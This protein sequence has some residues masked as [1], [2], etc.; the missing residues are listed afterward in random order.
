METKLAHITTQY[1]RF[2][3]NQV[4]TEGHLN[5][6][7]DYFDD[8]I[9]LSRIC[10]DGVGIVCGFNLTCNANNTLEISQGSAVTTDGDLFQMYQVDTDGNKSLATDA[11]VYTHFKAYVQ[12]P[13]K[14]LYSPY[15]FQGENQIPLFEL[16]T[17]GSDT[18]AK[19]IA[20]MLAQAGFA[21]KDGVALLYLENY[22]KEK[23]LCVSLSCDNQG[24]EIVG[25]YKV[26]VT[27]IAGA[28][29]IKSN[30]PTLTATNFEA[31]CYALPDVWHNRAIMLKEDFNSY[32][33]LKNK[34][35]QE[36][37][38]NDVINR[39]KS[40]YG[41]LLNTMGMSQL[42]TI[43][44]LKMDELFSY[45]ADNVPPDF[46]YRYDLLKDIIDSYSEIKTLLAVAEA[47]SCCANLDAF[48]KHIMLG[49]LTKSG[50]CYAYRHGFYKAPT[51]ISG[52]SSVCGSCNPETPATTAPF[53]IPE[54]VL[55][56]PE[57]NLDVCYSKDTSLDRI[58]SVI[59]RVLLMLTN[60][61]ANYS[62]VKV[63]PS[64]ELGPLRNK[65]IPFYYN[66]GNQLIAAWDFN[67][68]VVGK[69]H[70]N[71]SYHSGFLKIKEPLKFT[72]DHDFYRIEGH[73]GLN[74]LNVVSLLTELKRTHA[75]S[76]NVVA[77]PINATQE[78][79]VVDNY[80]QYYLTRNVGLDHKAG[81]VPGGTFVIIYIQGEYNGYPYPYGYGYPYGYPQDGSPFGADFEVLP[82]NDETTVLNP[83]VADFMLPYLCCD[84]NM[85]ECQLPVANLCFDESTSPLAFS[86]K[87]DGGFVSADVAVGLNGGVVLNEAG[88]FE[89]DPNLVS[90]EL[91]GQPI[92]FRV[93]NLETEC[94]ITIQPQINFQVSL[95]NTVYD[96]P[97][98]TATATLSLGDIEVPDGTAF[99]WDFGDGTPVV[100][101]SELTIDHVFNLGIVGETGALVRVNTSAGDCNSSDT[102]ALTFEVFTAISLPT[103][104]YCSNDARSHVFSLTPADST[105][106][107]AG[108]GVSQLG[109]NWVFVANGV[110]PGAVSFT[111]DGQPADLT[112]T[113]VQA[114]IAEFSVVVSETKI[115]ITNTSS[116]TDRYVFTI[117]GEEN[118]R[119]NRRS[120]TV[121]L[122][123]FT[124]DTIAISL[125]AESE[126]CGTD[127]FGP[128]EIEV[129]QGIA[130]CK[131]N[132]V[133]IV[134]SAFADLETIQTHPEFATL[135][136]PA[137]AYL[138]ELKSR[139]TL[140]NTNM[141]DFFNGDRNSDLPNLFNS[142]LYAALERVV[143]IADTDFQRSVSQKCI[144]LTTK[145]MY[146]MLNCQE[147]ALFTEFK[148]EI[149]DIL[150]RYTVVF[151]N[152][153]GQGF[154][155]D[156]NGATK[157]FLTVIEPRF[158]GTAFIAAQIETQLSFL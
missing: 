110:T 65:A 157:A 104:S 20:Q 44:N 2:T 130:T 3:K 7:L 40:G 121:P 28:A 94:E 107:I 120:F 17:N 83:I 23:D 91:Y 53:T 92:S 67:K 118:I 97:S 100:V 49:E 111:V 54:L 58:K 151:G 34:F 21:L 61:N 60:Y 69:Q 52:T 154:N 145:L 55:D 134:A 153:I 93:N 86:V 89:F 132:A 116:I 30:D 129:N 119:L 32:P 5:E 26:L 33:E 84:Q 41:L 68:T 25:N 18:D 109:S 128:L 64:F 16:H 85:A 14:V 19:P 98:N 50:S 90:P 71:L 102:I 99:T 82:E 113:V 46:Q 127:T 123:I 142:T 31:L 62:F 73:Q 146:T 152:L 108:P 87:P 63:T 35:A 38:K 124:T 27:T 81:V 56:Y 51:H 101:T 125:V 149:T 95:I 59:K 144:E 78:Q 131:D 11:K 139:Y 79:E 143:T 43:V 103:S 75:L 158:S 24:D 114:P 138:G 39:V 8:Q 72:I 135:Q 42:A 136:T 156:D 66:V 10:L 80:T 117:D 37:L 4:L 12:D 48:P 105:A 6:V 45:T 9:R 155:I 122:S 77:L 133:E 150:K 112:V 13:E 70:D 36:T 15:F 29:H 106:V 47:S 96:Q 137:V 115:S 76:F 74:Y 147:D 22:L 57:A 140:F 1:K 141:D 126:L 88:S 148:S